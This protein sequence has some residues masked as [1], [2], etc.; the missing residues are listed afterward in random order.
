MTNRRLRFRP[1]LDD[2]TQNTRM[3][4]ISGLPRLKSELSL[5]SVDCEVTS[6]T[7]EQFI[8]GTHEVMS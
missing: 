7:F 5:S 3:V 8:V 2:P 4:N 1:L 6:R